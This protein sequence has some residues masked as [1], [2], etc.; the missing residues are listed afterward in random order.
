M[1]D[2]EPD[3]ITIIICAAIAIVLPA[4]VIILGFYTAR[5]IIWLGII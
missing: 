4:I 3:I 5:L 2:K 1:S